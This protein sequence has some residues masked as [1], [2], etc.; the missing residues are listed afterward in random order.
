MSN[1][2][3]LQGEKLRGEAAAFKES[4]AERDMLIQDLRTRLSESEKNSNEWLRTVET[5]N[6]NLSER[7]QEIA[8]WQNFVVVIVVCIFCVVG[9]WWF[10]TP[11]PQATISLSFGW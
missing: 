1:M 10:C 11:K 7:D 4:L 5:A 9:G 6:K 3:S 2:F 8:N